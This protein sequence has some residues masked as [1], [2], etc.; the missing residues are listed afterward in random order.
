M[1][2]RLIG[3][4]VTLLAASLV[5]YLSLYLSPGSPEQVLFGSRPPS[6]EVQ[7]QVRHYLGLDQNVFVRYVDWLGNVLTGDL[8]TSLI[9]Q[10]PV[11]DRVAPAA[12][13]TLA[14]VA[15]AGVLV[16]L[17]GIGSGLLAALRP[18]KLDGA[19][20]AGTSVAVALPA[21][22]ASSLL[23]SVFA[24]NL[25]WFPAYGLGTGVGGWLRGLTLPAI[26]LAIIA[27]GLLARV[28]RSA[29][30][31]ELASEHVQ[32][33]TMRG[34]SHGRL[35]RSHVLRN[36]SAPIATVAG[37]QVAGLIAGAVVVEQAFGLGGLGG[38]LISSV[39]QKDFPV[40][41]AV[42]LIVVVGFVVLNLVADVISAIL[43]PRVR[44]AVS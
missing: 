37:L 31:A 26:S 13:V 27:S 20:T 29:A 5:V 36:A 24:V 30:R 3:L 44:R 18:G 12:E 39:Q 38:L 23:I 34:I 43:D 4:A 11:A 35:I 16:L 33:A 25:G 10:Q 19:V 22:V 17:L 2:H 15:Y 8:G 14:L 28:T 42:A 21:F 40:V 41:Q 1:L 9:T 6:P 32:T 7:E